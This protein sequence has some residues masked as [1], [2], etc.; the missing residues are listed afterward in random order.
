MDECPAA[1]ER[2]F[3]RV[4]SARTRI[5][6]WYVLLLAG[7]LV[8]GLLLQRTLLLNQVEAEVHDA[9]DQEVEEFRAL[10]E[11]GIDPETGEPFAG[12]LRAV[13]NTY[14]QRNVPLQGEGVVTIIDGR[15]FQGDAGGQQYRGT[16]LLE[17]WAAISRPTRRVVDTPQGRIAYLAVPLNVEGDQAGVFVVAIDMDER[18]EAANDLVQLGALVFGSIFLVASAVAWIV[19]GGVLRP[20]RLLGETARSITDSD[21]SR[22]IPVEGDDEIAELA[23]TFN[24]MLDRL[25]AAFAQQRRFVDDAGH[26]L[27]TPITVIRGNLELLSD[28]PDERHETLELVRR[29]L[30]GM[31]R[32]VEDLLALAKAE[33]PD[34][35]RLHPVDLPEF[36]QELEVRARS[37]GDRPLTVEPVAPVVFEGDAQRLHQAVMNLIRNA[38]EHTP[39]DA[40]VVLAAEVERGELRIRVSDTGPGIPEQERNAVF[41]R[42]ARGRAGRRTTTGAGLGLPIVAAIARGHGGSVEM[43][44]APGSGTTFTIIVPVEDDR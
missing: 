41:E 8:A 27:R 31:S 35:I 3:S 4:P 38:Y 29:E 30:D 18:L 7:A 1:S 37:L 10:A 9:L 23:R 11:Q 13:F 34:F 2:L 24:D 40:K 22:R 21:L 26:E 32:I 39:L 44:S 36:V 28:D 17:E 33:Q 14:L 19:A 6:G 15:P 5:L 25:Q 16:R 20:L 42:F 12:D 43:E